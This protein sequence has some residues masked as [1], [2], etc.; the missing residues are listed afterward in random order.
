[1]SFGRLLKRVRSFTGPVTIATRTR[2]FNIGGRNGISVSVPGLRL[3]GGGS[4][5]WRGISS[6][7]PVRKTIG[8]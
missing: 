3:F 2:S 7:S 8:K 4:A 6:R 1:M 5:G